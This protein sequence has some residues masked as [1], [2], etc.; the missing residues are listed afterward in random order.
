MRLLVKSGTQHRKR[1]RSGAGSVEVKENRMK[2]Y[3]IQM[4]YGIRFT[5]EGI[6]AGTQEEAVRKARKIVEEGITILPYD[7]SVDVGNLG[8]E[9]AMCLKEDK[10]DDK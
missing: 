9:S 2:S 5:V 4:N 8:F 1:L 6:K 7:C 10:H 3:D